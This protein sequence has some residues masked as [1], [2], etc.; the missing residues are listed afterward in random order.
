MN[1]SSVKIAAAISAV[2]KGVWF[3]A[4]IIARHAG[5]QSKTAKKYL[6][7]WAD[8]GMLITGLVDYRPHIKQELF[9]LPTGNEQKQLEL[10]GMETE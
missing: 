2:G 8:E 3:S 4:S 6:K 7:A 5:C 10:P 1:N 9:M